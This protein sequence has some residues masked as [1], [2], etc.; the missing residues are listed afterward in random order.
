[1]EAYNCYQLKTTSGIS[2][3]IAVGADDA[4]FI[5][6]SVAQGTYALPEGY[7]A[8]LALAGPGTKVIDLG[9]NIGTFSLAA[10]AIGCE[11]VAVEASPHNAALLDA[12]LAAN[13][14]AG[15]QVV[16]AAVGDRDGGTVEFVQAGPFGF[17][18][19]AQQTDLPRVQV[20]ATTVDR[21]LS[22]V[23]W[24]RVDLIKMD[25]E[26]AEVATVR[27]MGGLLRRDDAPIILF[28]SNGHT[29]QYFGES[30][31]TLLAALEGFG[32][33]NYL[34]AENRLIRT[35][36]AT[37]QPDCIVDYLAVKEDLPSTWH[38]WQVVGHL[39]DDEYLA[40][41]EATARFPHEHYRA[42][43]ARALR[44]ADWARLANPR[45]AAILEGLVAD[46]DA[47]VRE[48]ADWFRQHRVQTDFTGRLA[49]VE[50]LSA[51]ADI[52]LRGYVVRSNVPVLGKV[53]AW[54][55]NNMTSHLREPY[56]DRMVER[57]VEFNRKVAQEIRLLTQSQAELTERLAQLE[58]RRDACGGKTSS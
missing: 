29:L 24:A 26:G 10:A 15:M 36:A 48:A 57:Q 31:Q 4:D 23:G 34:V 21:L 35:R 25:V 38:G 44:G 7:Y 12:S 32:Y 8:L 39:G 27:G 20:R 19:G 56:V 14:F 41:L 5:S 9:A 13:R 42:Y 43:V 45:V 51:Q 50:Q 3:K 28:E 54:V 2:C 40:R 16:A 49:R 37:V 22:D 52:M 30:P 17:V 47:T 1:L 58:A 55:R 11:V 33:R 18:S 53:I 46:Q 6:Q